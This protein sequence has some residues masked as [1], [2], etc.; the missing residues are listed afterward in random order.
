MS[1]GFEKEKAY[2]ETLSALQSVLEGIDDRVAMMATMSCIFKTNFPYYFWVGFYV[3]KGEGLIIGPYQGTLGCLTIA[4]GRGVCGAAAERG[5]TIVVED[6]H[7]FPGHIACDPNSQSEIVVPVR[8]Q[9]G[10][11][12]AVFDVDS[13]ETGSFNDIDRL[14]LERIMHHFFGEQETFA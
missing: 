9:E 13:A 6:V 14:W 1:Q 3:L 4:M 5:E 8:D 10:R 7:E 11:L 2:Q 12:I